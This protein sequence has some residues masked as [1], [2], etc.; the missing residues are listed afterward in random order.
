MVGVAEWIDLN[1]VPFAAPAGDAFSGE[2]PSEVGG[3]PV[4]A[5]RAGW[6]LAGVDD[7][8]AD[9]WVDGS[10]FD[11]CD[12]N[13]LSD[14]VVGVRSENEVGRVVRGDEALRRLMRGVCAGDRTGIPRKVH[15]VD[16]TGL[17]L[18]EVAGDKTSTR[19]DRTVGGIELVALDDYAR[20]VAAAITDDDADLGIEGVIENSDVPGDE[21]RCGVD[22][23]AAGIR[24][25]G[26][27]G[28]G[29]ILDGEVLNSVDSHEAIVVEVSQ[30]AVGEGEP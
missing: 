5:L 18:A 16:I 10:E 4:I 24:G 11:D 8:G 23:D 25:I 30:D 26:V 27:V 9:H 14:G 2:R 1:G 15:A 17:G 3:D 20:N 7:L 21:V 6:V 12:L 13:V 28:N 29:G 19:R 22:H